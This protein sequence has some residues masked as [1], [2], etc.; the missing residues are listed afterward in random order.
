M[1]LGKLKRVDT[2]DIKIVSIPINGTYKSY[3]AET[4]G[5]HIHILETQIVLQQADLLEAYKALVELGVDTK[6]NKNFEKYQHCQCGHNN[7]H[8]PENEVVHRL[9]CIVGKALKYIKEREG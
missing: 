4:L 2:D 9:D 3:F 8:H 7:K 5:E 6:E 1:K